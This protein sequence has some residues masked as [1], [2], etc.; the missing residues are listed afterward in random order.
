MERRLQNHDT[1]HNAGHH[2]VTPESS[3]L[4]SLLFTDSMLHLKV[5]QLMRGPFEKLDMLSDSFL[6]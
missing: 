2:R 4:A 1:K 6:A 3:P 5:L